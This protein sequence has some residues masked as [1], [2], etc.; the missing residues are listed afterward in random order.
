MNVE[1]AVLWVGIVVVTTVIAWLNHLGRLETEKTIREAIEKGTIVDAETIE[2]LRRASAVPWQ[3]RL[4]AWAIFTI[5]L[6]AGV[7][8]FALTISD[9]ESEALRPLLGIAALLACVAGGLAACGFW[10]GKES[11]V[12]RR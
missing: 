5:S 11:D 1:F 8:L 3:R 9:Q 2:R 7:A 12:T 10:L 4:V 6:A